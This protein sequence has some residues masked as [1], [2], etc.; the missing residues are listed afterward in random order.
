MADR[1][2]VLLMVDGVRLVAEVDPGAMF[3]RSSKADESAPPRVRGRVFRRTP[4]FDGDLRLPLFSM[5]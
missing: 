3:F 2:T 4:L 1:E 5:Q